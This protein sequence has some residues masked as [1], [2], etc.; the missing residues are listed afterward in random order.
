MYDNEIFSLETLKEAY[1]NIISELKLLEEYLSNYIKYTKDIRII[2]DNKSNLI[3]FNS[4]INNVFKSLNYIKNNTV[5]NTDYGQTNKPFKYI[6]SGHDTVR[7]NFSQLKTVNKD[8]N[9]LK[10]LPICKL[11]SFSTTEELLHGKIYRVFN[12]N[13]LNRLNTKDCFEIKIPIL[14]E[15]DFASLSVLES[16]DA[17]EEIEKILILLNLN[18]KRLDLSM[19]HIINLSN[20]DYP[21]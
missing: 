3:S 13:K 19:K 18:I 21:I 12:I 7:I 4:Q 17:L 5:L 20:L 16:K 1:D 2:N 8:I 11:S 10:L 14:K 9:T 6:G 15:K